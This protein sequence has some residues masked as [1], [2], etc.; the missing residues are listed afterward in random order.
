MISGLPRRWTAS[1]AVAAVAWTLMA[2]VASV[3]G[4]DAMF[5]SSSDVVQASQNVTIS[6][7]PRT[8]TIA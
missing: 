6:K 8:L 1:K 2:F 7:Y 3:S 5:S 4:V